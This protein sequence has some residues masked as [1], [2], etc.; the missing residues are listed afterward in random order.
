MALDEDSGFTVSSP[1]WKLY[2]GWRVDDLLLRFLKDRCLSRS[3]CSKATFLPLFQTGSDYS[4]MRSIC[5]RCRPYCSRPWFLVHCSRRS[6]Y[7]S[8]YCGVDKKP[9]VISLL[10]TEKAIR[11]EFETSLEVFLEV[12]RTVFEVQSYDDSESSDSGST[13][14]WP[15][16]LTSLLLIRYPT[17]PGEVRYSDEWC[18]D[19]LF[20]PDRMLGNWSRDVMGLCLSVGSG[21]NFGMADELDDE[22]FLYW[23]QRCRSWDDGFGAARPWVLEWRVCTGERV[24]LWWEILYRGDSLVLGTRCWASPEYYWESCGAR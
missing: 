11:D 15:A 2:D 9:L 20:R 4:Y 23:E 17:T 10:S 21:G 8:A 18:T 1:T 5:W 22:F 14:R 16:T 13:G 24:L 12:I 19:A 3:T 6:H 7:F